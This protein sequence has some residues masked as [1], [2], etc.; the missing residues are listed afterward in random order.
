MDGV[1]IIELLIG[2]GVVNFLWKIQRELGQIN[3]SLDN[4]THIVDDHE[5]RLRNIEGKE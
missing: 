3:S 5:Q 1:T 4:L 2:C